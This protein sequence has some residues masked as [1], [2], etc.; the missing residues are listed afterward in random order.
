MKKSSVMMIAA[1]LILS[2][3]GT[4]GQLVSS[5]EGQQFQD[6][7]YSNVP[8]FRSKAEKDEGRQKA[9]TLAAE[10]K[11]SPIYLFGDR[12]DT[13]MIPENFSATIRYD[14]ALSSTV[15]TVGE[16]PYDWRNNINPWN[17]YTPYS[18]GSS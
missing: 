8:D 2:S 17:V 4:L 13:V 6:G 7:I 1:A 3:C 18:I 15:V 11:E 9:E 5:G 10:T 16:N 14:K 12:K